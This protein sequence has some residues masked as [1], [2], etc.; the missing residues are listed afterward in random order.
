MVPS[1]HRRA[2]RAAARARRGRHQ[3]RSSHEGSEPAPWPGRP[4]RTRRWPWLPPPHADAE[5]FRARLRPSLLGTPKG[6][7]VT[8]VLVGLGVV[9]LLAVLLT[10]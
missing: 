5:A 1:Y 4:P 10:K 3:P 8:L 6:A 2:A 7:L 9:L